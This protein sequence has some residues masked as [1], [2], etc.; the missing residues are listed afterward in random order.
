[1]QARQSFLEA[2]H[3]SAPDIGQYRSDSG[4]VGLGTAACDG[5]RANAGI[6]QIADL[7][8]RTSGRNALPASDLGAVISGAG[9]YLCPTYRGALNPLPP[10]S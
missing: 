2:V 4:L 8:E 1:V 9:R 7:I 10:G 3:T 6:Q 5:F